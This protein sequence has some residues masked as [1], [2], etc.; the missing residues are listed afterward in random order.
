MYRIRR[1]GIAQT[2]TTVAAIYALSVAIFAIPVAILVA[3]VGGRNGDGASSAVFV[4]LIA[5]LAILFY[6]A[7]AWLFTA[8]ACAIYN[9]VA[10]WVGGIAVQV[11]I[12]APPPPPPL[13]GP[14][15]TDPHPPA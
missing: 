3:V 4:I 10:G 6:G 14:V 13:W 12:E 15:T 5:A 11:E 9:V 1:F 2:A 7:A 8:I